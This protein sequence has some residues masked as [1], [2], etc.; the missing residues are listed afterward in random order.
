MADERWKMV[1]STVLMLSLAPLAAEACRCKSRTLD[2]AVSLADFV[3]LARVERK[4]MLSSSEMRID[5]TVLES[6][7]G[8]IEKPLSVMST[9]TCMYDVEAGEEHLLF[10]RDDPN[11]GLHTDICSGNHLA[12]DPEGQA[13]LEHLR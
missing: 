12:K 10:I 3:A 6:F 11:F 8:H 5:L 2:E 4:E 1:I 9:S 13:A 7:K